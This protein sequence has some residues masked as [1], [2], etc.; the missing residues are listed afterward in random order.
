[1][2]VESRQLQGLNSGTLINY[3]NEISPSRTIGFQARRQLV[4]R[5]SIAET[6]NEMKDM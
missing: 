1:M 6:M 5:E 4:Q 2:N 3:P